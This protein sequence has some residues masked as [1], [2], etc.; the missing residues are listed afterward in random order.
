MTRPSLEKPVLLFDGDCG[1]CRR[2]VRRWELRAEGRVECVPYQEAGE[3]AAGLPPGALAEAVHLVLPDGT[4]A[5]G[6]EAVF[7]CQALSPGG[8]GLYWAYRRVPG[9]KAASE[10]FYSLVA[11]HRVFFSRLTRW[12]WGADVEPETFEL[13]RWLFLRALGVVFLAAFASLGVQVSGLL[14]REGLA[15]AA[16]LLEAARTQLGSERYRLFPTLCWLA[17][18]DGFLR[19]LC[20]GG[21]ALS[22]LLVAGVL[23][24]A[25]LLVLW[26]FYLSLTAVGGDF[27]AFQWDALLIETGFL[28]AFLAPWGLRPSGKDSAPAPAP[29]LWLLRWLLFRLMFESGCVKLLSGDPAWRGLTALTH[30]FQTQPLPTALAWHAH[31]LPHGLLRASCAAMFAIELAAPLLILLPR[32]PRLLGFAALVLL[33]LL[34]ALTG[35]YGFFNLLTLALCLLL[36]D[37]K[38]LAPV[39]P[40]ALARRIAPA[41]LRPSRARRY[42]AV[43]LA[44]AVLLLSGARL[45]GLFARSAVPRPLAAA[46]EAAAPLRTVN[47]YGLFA[48]M[49]TRRLEISVEGSAD[50]K[51]WSEYKFRWKPG[52]ASRA[53]GWAAP[54]QPRLDWQMWFAAL[55]PYQQNPWFMNLLVRLAQGSKPVL[56]LL[57]NDP[58]PEAPPRHLRAV[59][60]DYRF[61]TRAERRETGAWWKREPLGLYLPVLSRRD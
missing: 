17:S 58:F 14:G 24:G 25:L 11:N 45:L 41:R 2:W 21:A 34:I 39:V 37:D 50:G 22:A 44:A 13:S 8:G 55:S 38:T 36:L 30:H 9:F 53:P 47:G 59:V 40:R 18:S 61:A 33:Q 49:T 42:W 7:R 46:F 35:N 60:Y 23:P 1:F 19:F 16:Q 52:D 15:P 3:R 48:V 43:P 20:W 26:A 56:G 57:E 10:S 5:R 12:L 54:H 6:A 31:Q 32:R 27:M 28:A 51:S 29:A 4:A